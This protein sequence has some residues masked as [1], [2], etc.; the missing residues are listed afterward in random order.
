M[1]ERIS[2]ARPTYEILEEQLTVFS[3]EHSEESKNLQ[4][5]L[6]QWGAAV[7]EA[8]GVETL[9]ELVV[10]RIEQS[11]ANIN[12]EGDKTTVEEYVKSL[13]SPNETGQITADTIMARLQLGA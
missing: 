3:K 7:M 9:G 13:F 6:M 2:T 12:Y 8:A 10:L 11:V 4:G 1:G 5:E